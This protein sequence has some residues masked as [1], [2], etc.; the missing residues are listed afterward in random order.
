M[1]FYKCLLLVM[2]W[3]VAHASPVVNGSLPNAEAS[4]PPAQ[5]DD[6]AG[7][8]FETILETQRRQTEIAAEDHELHDEASETPAAVENKAAASTSDEVTPPTD[9]RPSDVR[10]KNN[11]PV[12]GIDEVSGQMLT[13]ETAEMA[14]DDQV[15]VR[16]HPADFPC[17]RKYEVPALI[18]QHILQKHIDIST[19]FLFGNDI[20]GG[21][22][23][24]KTTTNQETAPPTAKMAAAAS[25]HPKDFACMQQGSLLGQGGCSEE[26]ACT[27]ATAADSFVVT[28]EPTTTPHDDI[29]Q[30]SRSVYDFF[31]L[32]NMEVF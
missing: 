2:L 22:A 24:Q 27:T 6:V 20:T 31:N 11:K 9:N 16:C 28:T 8:V 26:A 4:A 7:T 3:S 5:E 17:R 18:R 21:D 1:D 29:H 23:V 25:C 10:P 15:V 13:T 14:S 12:D 32:L 30:K 19:S